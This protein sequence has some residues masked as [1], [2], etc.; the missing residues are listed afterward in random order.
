[1]SR[2][3]VFSIKKA[4]LCTGLRVALKIKS[5][6]GAILFLWWMPGTPSHGAKAPAAGHSFAYAAR[7]A[8]AF[9]QNAR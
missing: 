9:Y 3:K 2:E 6:V 8:L 4:T 5:P 1:M 7:T